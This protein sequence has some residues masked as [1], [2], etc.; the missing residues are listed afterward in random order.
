MGWITV[1]T[2]EAFDKIEKA[3][4]HGKN[5]PAFDEEL[6]EYARIRKIDPGDVVA[7]FR[8]V[9]AERGLRV[10]EKTEFDARGGR[11]PQL[12]VWFAILIAPVALIMWLVGSLYRRIRG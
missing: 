4:R 3:V 8:T 9:G 5:P 11:I 7:H 2:K 10:L 1:D 12:R 6:R